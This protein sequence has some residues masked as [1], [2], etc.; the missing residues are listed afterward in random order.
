MDVFHDAFLRDEIHTPGLDQIAY[1]NTHPVPLT[2]D[3]LDTV[4]PLHHTHPLA[5]VRN[6]MAELD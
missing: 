5:S 2:G 1:A 6:A 4:E 3:V